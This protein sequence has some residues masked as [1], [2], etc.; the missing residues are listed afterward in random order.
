MASIQSPLFFSQG[1]T[2]EHCT[3]PNYW[4]GTMEFIRL[5]NSE[6]CGFMPSREHFC[7]GNVKAGDL[8]DFNLFL[9]LCH[10][11]WEDVRNKLDATHVFPLF[12]LLGTLS[13]YVS[14][15]CS[16]SF[17]CICLYPSSFIDPNEIIH[18]FSSDNVKLDG[19]KEIYFETCKHFT[20]LNNSIWKIDLCSY[21]F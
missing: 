4:I 7:P 21:F 2:S 14:A 1:I 3:I 20:N 19:L 18:S 13:G 8:S 6:V 12:E 10:A 17:S 5:P 16:N 9:Q 11:F 15:L